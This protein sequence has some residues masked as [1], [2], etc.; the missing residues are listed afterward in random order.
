MRTTRLAAVTMGAVTIVALVSACSSQSS[1]GVAPA[2]QATSGFDNYF[3][4]N[5]NGEDTLDV[6]TGGYPTSLGGCVGTLGYNPVYITNTTDVPQTV[7]YTINS[8]LGDVVT[9]A[10]ASVIQS[11]PDCNSVGG[12]AVN[13]AQLTIPPGQTWYGGVLAAGQNGPGTWLNDS[14]R[15][16]AIGGGDNNQWYD[17]W[18]HTDA[19]QGFQNWELNYSN[20]G[21]TDPSQNLQAGLFNVMEC[22]SD[23]GGGADTQYTISNTIASPYS[24]NAPN[25]WTYNNNDPICLA[26]LNAP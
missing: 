13:N 4:S 22:S 26:F 18:L 10:G 17:F 9:V 15:N 16:L 12:D 19:N 25:A 23:T 3:D 11:I 7:T 6:I 8:E 14:D 5:P 20:T 1:S 21:G 24:S 2:V